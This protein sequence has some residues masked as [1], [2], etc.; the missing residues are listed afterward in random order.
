MILIDIG[1]NLMNSAFDRDRETV[2]RTAAAAGVFPLVITGSSLESSA[3]AADF[4]ER[5]N[6]ENDAGSSLPPGFVPVRGLFTTAGIHPHNAKSWNGTAEKLRALASRGAAAIG[7]CGL[8]YYRDY[9]PRNMQ[10]ACFEAQVELAAEMKLPLFLHEREAFG[11]FSEVLKRNR[12]ALS[13]MVVH[14]FTGGEQELETYLELDCY[15]GVTGWICDERRGRRLASLVKRI[16]PDRLL[17]ETDA[18]Y[19]MPR[20]MPGKRP[21]A[22][23]E[24]ANLVHIAAF[25]AG[26]LDKEPAALAEETSANARRLFRLPPGI[27]A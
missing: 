20:N 7:E 15:I 25:I 19:L 14:C 5:Y 2:I 11:D 3:A 13:P 22:R 26:L 9:S 17:L 16:P 12:N 6:R 24:P 18:P 23:N 10:R 8:D 1:V 21:S 4:A 27:I